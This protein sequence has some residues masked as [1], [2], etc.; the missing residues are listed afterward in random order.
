MKK[1]K[2]N[3]E[4]LKTEFETIDNDAM[5]LISGGYDCVFNLMGYLS[6][7]YGGSNSSSYYYSNYSGGWQYDSSGNTIGISS[8]SAQ[9]YLSQNFDYDPTPSS[10]EVYNALHG[11]D[12]ATVIANIYMGGITHAVTIQNQLPDGSYL[13]YDPSS[14]QTN[15]IGT[16]QIQSWGLVCGSR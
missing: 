13:V 2:L 14:G 12:S 10:L 6:S 5:R 16:G 4:E 11:Y 8:T 9:G 3:F 15:Q 1:L 7:Q